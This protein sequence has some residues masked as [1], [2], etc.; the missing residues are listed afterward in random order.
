MTAL[1]PVALLAAC[2]TLNVK[3]D[4]NTTLMNSA[5]C[6][7]YAWA[8]AFHGGSPMRETIA[9][10]L[11]ESRL[12]AAIS[13]HLGAV[14]AAPDGA[15]CLVGYG[16][17]SR[18]VVDG[19]WPGYGPGWGWGGGW[20]WGPGW[21]WGGW[22]GPW[23]SGVYVYDQGVISVDIYDAR[24]RQPLWHASV[25][26]NLQNATGAEAE[27][28]INSAV[29]AIFMK[30]PGVPPGTVPGAAPRTAPAPAAPTAASPSA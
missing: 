16:I 4:A 28:R 13:S 14:Q 1:A 11:N 24:S 5:H 23:D 17:G 3:T 22:G 26:Q 19:A 29:D 20:G 9:N 8:G 18:Q 27:R 2:Q 21:G 25:N 7:S 10:P 12:R 15:E 6:G 30:Y